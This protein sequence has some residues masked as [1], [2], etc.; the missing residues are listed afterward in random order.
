MNKEILGVKAPKESC[1]DMKCPFHGEINVKN[2]LFQGKVV[3]KDINHS[4]TIEWFRP[5]PVPKYERFEIRRSRMRVHNPP[6]MDAVIGSNVLVAR[7]RPLSKTKHHVIIKIQDSLE[8]VIKVKDKKDQ[9]EEKSE[10]KENH[11]SS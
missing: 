9:L 3:K 5:Y 8:G 2:E 7:T 10:K 11:E 4:A 1:T 6:C